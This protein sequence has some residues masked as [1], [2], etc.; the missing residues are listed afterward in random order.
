MVELNN[1]EYDV[2]HAGLVTIFY[3]VIYSYPLLLVFLGTSIFKHSYVINKSIH[4]ISSLLSSYF[5]E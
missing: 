2:V 3:A 5:S 4:E 1:I